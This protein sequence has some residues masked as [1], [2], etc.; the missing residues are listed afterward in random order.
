[1][2]PQRLW[3]GLEADPALGRFRQTLHFVDFFSEDTD[4]GAVLFLGSLQLIDAGSQVLVAGQEFPH[5]NE[6]ADDQNAHLDGALAV[7]YRR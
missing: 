6:R 2:Q 7:E 3:I 1:M 4:D 5:L